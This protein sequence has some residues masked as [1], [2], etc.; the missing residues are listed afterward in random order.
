MN[1]NTIRFVKKDDFKSLLE[2]SFT[3]ALKKEELIDQMN[4]ELQIN[5]IYATIK[6]CFCAEIHDEFSCAKGVTTT[7]KEIMGKFI[8]ENA[9]SIDLN[10]K[11]K[12]I[13]IK[14]ISYTI[15]D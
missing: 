3:K 15:I 9:L 13:Y 4:F 1:Q 6:Y 8:D 2:D 14:I 10:T 5:S 11:E 12:T 7:F